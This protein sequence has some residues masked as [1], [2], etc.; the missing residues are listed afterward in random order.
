M[1]PARVPVPLYDDGLSGSRWLQH[2]N[3]GR[4][5]DVGAIDVSQALMG[6]EVRHVNIVETDAVLEPFASQD[7]FI[8]GYPLGRLTGAPSPVWKRGTIATDPTFDPDGL[9][10]MYVDSA[11]RA[12]MSGSVVVAR[13]IVVGKSVT[14]KDGVETGPFLY[15]VRDIV[16]GIYAGRLGA[17]LVQAQL[18]I[19]WKRNALRSNWKAAPEICRCGAEKASVAEHPAGRA[20][21]ASVPERAGSPAFLWW[22]LRLQAPRPNDVVLRLIPLLDLELIA[23]RRGRELRLCESSQEPCNRSETAHCLASLAQRSRNC[24]TRASVSASFSYL[25]RVLSELG[26]ARREIRTV[27]KYHSSVPATRRP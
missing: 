21:R 9:P 1:S 6:L 7:V 22:Q 26:R 27:G 23:S 25:S 14:R 13:H 10:K 15:A 2:P 18:G 20:R 3:F 19:V 12:G 11:T 8:V 16:L 24:A 5:V 4:K 17:D